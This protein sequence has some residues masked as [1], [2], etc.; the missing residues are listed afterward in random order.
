[1]VKELVALLDGRLIF[2]YSMVRYANTREI[3]FGDDP[4]KKCCMCIF[5]LIRDVQKMENGGS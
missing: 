5:V 1:M 4:C 2:L 3:E